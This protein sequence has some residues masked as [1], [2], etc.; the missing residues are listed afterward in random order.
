MGPFQIIFVLF[1]KNGV[2]QHLLD[3]YTSFKKC[4]SLKSFMHNEIWMLRMHDIYD[5]DCEHGAKRIGKKDL[6]SN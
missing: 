2:Q 4:P 5:R 1:S 3:L 6:D